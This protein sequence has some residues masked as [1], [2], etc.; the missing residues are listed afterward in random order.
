MVGFIFSDKH[1][2]PSGDACAFFP[3]WCSI[4]PPFLPF[5]L[6]IPLFLLS[7]A[8]ARPVLSTFRS[9]DQ[10][11]LFDNLVAQFVGDWAQVSEAAR[12]AY[13]FVFGSPLQISIS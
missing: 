8:A 10:V 5:L 3:G 2:C 11:E 1:A 6:S 12:Q 7:L 9:S 4:L 13:Q